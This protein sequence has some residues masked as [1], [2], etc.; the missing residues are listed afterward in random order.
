MP[1]NL[2]THGHEMPS[3]QQPRTMK[4]L[5]F[6]AILALASTAATR[7]PTSSPPTVFDPAGI[8]AYVAGQVKEKGIVGLSLVMMREGKV[9]LARAYGSRS[10]EPREPATT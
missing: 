9:E 6:I 4:L 10:L 8:D 2:R 3:H 1:P 5:C 7:K